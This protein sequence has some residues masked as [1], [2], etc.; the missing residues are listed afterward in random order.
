VQSSHSPSKYVFSCKRRVD[1][2]GTSAAT[3]LAERHFSGKDFTKAFRGNGF[4]WLKQRTR[5]KL[6]VDI[7]P[8]NRNSMEEDGAHP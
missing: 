2:L 7:D 4:V 8:N 5:R 3:T 1:L 6:A